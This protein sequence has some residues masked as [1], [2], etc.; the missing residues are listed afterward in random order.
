MQWISHCKNGD[1]YSL[2]S[3]NI[4]S[5]EWPCTF[6]FEIKKIKN[7]IKKISFIMLK[8]IVHEIYAKM[9][10]YFYFSIVFEFQ[11]IFYFFFCFEKNRK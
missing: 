6:T 11:L 7:E 9:V 1:A 5:F 3:P 2:L 8:T 10:L 4:K